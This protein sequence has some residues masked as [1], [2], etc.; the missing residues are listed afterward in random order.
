MSR[1]RLIHGSDLHLS[2]YLIDHINPIEQISSASAR[3]QGL[4]AIKHHFISGHSLWNVLYPSS[5]SPRTACCLHKS[6][7][8]Q[9]G[10]ADAAVFTGDL[11]T[12]GIK[13]DLEVAAD[14][15]RGNLPIDWHGAD[16]MV[17]G[18]LLDTEAPIFLMPGNHDRFDGWPG[19]PGIRPFETHFGP[20]WDLW[21]GR[22]RLGANNELTRSRSRYA[23]LKKDDRIL[24]IVF[25]DFSHGFI[26]EA[27]SISGVCGQGYCSESI[28]S[29]AAL[30]TET[31]RNRLLA[32][33]P[34]SSIGTIWCTHFPPRFPEIEHS[35]DL[36][37]ADNLLRA[38]ISANVQ[39]LLS[40]H[41]H[42]RKI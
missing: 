36:L 22:G 9:L 33:H 15:F 20:C 10:T 24:L 2:K 14:F 11:A 25:I 1:F 23:C 16:G 27:D 17:F 42:K 30:T 3:K 7:K 31:V 19:Y 5:F 8:E 12:T 38:A 35:L 34:T 37:R 29:E 26:S 39:I 40:G 41:T 21:S 4:E 32:A 28:S 18:S 13:G 6:I